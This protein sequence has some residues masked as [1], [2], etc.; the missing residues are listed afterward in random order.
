MKTI[1]NNLYI[2]KLIWKISKSA[3]LIKLFHSIF[4]AILAPFFILAN[5]YLIDMLTENSSDWHLFISI[6]IIMV[7]ADFLTKSLN[8]VMS[9]HVN[10]HI[11]WKFNHGINI[12]LMKNCV[13]LDLESFDNSE[14]YNKYTLALKT[15]DGV[16]YK[17]FGQAFSLLTNILNFISVISVLILLDP[18]VILFALAGVAINLIISIMIQKLNHKLDVEFS[19]PR[20]V[21]RYIK[22]RIIYQ[23]EYA[24]DIR[25]TPSLF[26]IFHKDYDKTLK[27]MLKMSKRHGA[28]YL[29][30]EIPRVFLLG[31]LELGKMLYLAHSVFFGT[32][33]AG[34]FSALM[35][36]S[37]HFESALNG[38]GNS[39]S[40][41]VRTGLDIENLMTIKGKKGVIETS[42]G[43]ELDT[44]EINICFE[45]VSFSYSGSDTPVLKNLNF[46]IFDNDRV[47]IVGLNGA[48]K[49]TL[50]K[51]L[52]RLYDP[53]EGRITLN[54]R[55]LRE[56][57]V[58]SLRK[59]IATVFQ[60]FNIYALSL[61]KNVSKEEC[62]D[63][64]R[65]TES[66][67]LAGFSKKVEGLEK[68][69]DTILS[70]EFGDGI[71][72]SGGESQKVAI[73]SA[74]YKNAPILIFDEPTA[75]LDPMAEHELFEK[76]ESLF[77]ER[78]TVM[79]SHRLANVIH[80][81]KILYLENGVV[82]EEG[83]HQ[84]LMKKEGKYFKLFT[85]Q[86]KEYNLKEHLPEEA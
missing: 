78:T 45:N 43:I 53:T 60:D 13:E 57:S 15:A 27:D 11:M 55:D 61:E 8:S 23:P 39:V 77:A 26:S 66:I 3:F 76:I 25:M 82:A 48:G 28:K 42:D 52:C 62:A 84:E 75:S 29:L 46:T 69:T 54:G 70:T 71:N 31:A 36:S 21:Q 12:E 50:V 37:E 32:A 16:A 79:I 65:L 2:L 63:I 18:I 30:L 24:K 33:T 22:E 85:L 19:L 74:L 5:K 20:R 67:E 59:K 64:E 56:Y 81:N 72:L 9:Y 1:K 51:L 41:F 4:T 44:D 6:I 38:L 80:C 86:A 83:S 68:G 35:N 7:L 58:H 49:S 73:A 34:T 10:S 17:V 47:A 40:S 14:F